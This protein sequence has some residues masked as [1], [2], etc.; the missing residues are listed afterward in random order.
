MQITIRPADILSRVAAVL[1]VALP[2]AALLQWLSRVEAEDTARMTF[3][4][5]RKY[6]SEGANAT[7]AADYARILGFTTVYVLVVEG[8]AFLM[9]LTVRAVRPTEPTGERY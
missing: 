5:L 1:L 9:R 8:L 6:L 3:D 2:L 7:F 4:E